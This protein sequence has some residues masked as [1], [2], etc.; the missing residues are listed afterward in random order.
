MPTNEGAACDDTLFCTVGDHCAAGQC[1]G[2]PKVCASP[3]DACMT[4]QC[5]EAGN[6]CIVVPGN[7]GAACDD[8]NA[9]TQG[10]VCNA[11]QCGGGAPVGA[12]GAYDDGNGCTTM[13]TCNANGGC[14]GGSSFWVHTE[15]VGRLPRVEWLLVTPSVHRVH[16]A[17]NDVY[18]DKNFGGVL[19]VWDRLFGTYRVEDEAPV[20]GSSDGLDTWSPLRVQVDHAMRLARRAR[21]L[22]RLSDRL[23][24]WLRGPAWRSAEEG[25]LERNHG[26]TLRVKY[27]VA[28][29][30]ARLLA[31]SAI[32]AVA[33]AATVLVM[34]FRDRLPSSIVYGA[35]PVIAVIL[36]LALST[37]E[38]PVEESVSRRRAKAISRSYSSRS[39]RCSL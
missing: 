18:L 34:L 24:A 25:P 6:A 4:G 11:G 28:T 12:G 32:F 23:S 14:I 39:H 20:Y 5:D 37:A 26:V 27:D 15:L 16:R 17:V 7:D 19:T 21:R 2:D 29:T 22:T 38:V 10:E 13:D 9:C 30:R 3:A 1:V 31:S 35:V 33:L 36:S 8:A